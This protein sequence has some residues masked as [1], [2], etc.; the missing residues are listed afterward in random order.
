ME[1]WSRGLLCLFC[2]QVR[3]CTTALLH[4][5]KRSGAAIFLVGHVTKSGDIA[6]PKALEH[7]VDV[8]LYMEGDR[9]SSHRLLRGIKNRRVGGRPMAA[10]ACICALASPDR[11]RVAPLESAA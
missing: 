11:T 6:G 5:A 7:I 9:M 2:T 1:A 4:A 10:T 8:V 3:E